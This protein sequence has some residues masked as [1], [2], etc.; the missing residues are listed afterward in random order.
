MSEYS[1][2]AAT[3]CT[4][5]AIRPSWCSG[6]VVTLVYLATVTVIV[7]VLTGGRYGFHRDE[8]ATLEDARHLA[9][10]YVAYP[11]VTPFFARTAL[12]LFGTSLAGF[13]LFAA[14]AQAV[15][16]VLTG[17]MA[18]ELSGTRWAQLVAATAAVPFC[19][20]GGALMQYLSFDYLCWVLTAYFTLRL[21]KSD[22]PRWWIAIGSS[23]GLGMLSKYTMPFFIAGLVVAVLATDL[24]K[25]LKNK[26]L[27]WGVVVSVVIFLPNLIWQAQHNF[28]SLDFLQNIHA[29]DVREGKA[30][31]FLP[32][33]LKVTLFAFPLCMA[34]LYFYL[35]SPRGK[36]FRM[37]GW[38]YVVPLLLFV[39][40][41]GREY[42][43]APAYPMLYAAGSVAAEAWLESARPSW[44]SILR[45]L[46]WTVLVVD[47]AIAAAFTLPLAPV[48]S[49]WFMMA[50]E[51]NGDFQCEEI[52]WPELVETVAHIRDS[53]PTQDRVHLGIL[54][55]NY[56]EA[57]AVNLYGTQYGL[58]RAI[59]GVNSFSERGYG[60]PPP[61]VV[62][63][64]GLPREFVDKKF[65]AC[66]L[67]ARSWNRF[68]VPNEETLQHPDIFVCRGLLQSWP[69]FWKDFRSFG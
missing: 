26:W 18:R 22:D 55:T 3:L 51:V 35:F 6:D 13:R 49:A 2:S 15:A 40:A 36:R 5:Q 47:I 65:A 50:R 56:G 46:V 59:S 44:A 53:L 62:I 33:Q 68:K 7:H 42:Y 31:G 14:V 1:P 29:R 45:R 25:H 54:A 24:R 43:V 17:L 64:L 61:Q 32:G 60:N 58:P 10:G 28:V 21:L 4:R 27:W 52:G 63:V 20:G 16:L 39:I 9:W 57:G 48:N 37:L 12:E 67:A 38:M 66:Q 34:G 41:K 11:P 23:I 19:L 8:L 69:E 30:R